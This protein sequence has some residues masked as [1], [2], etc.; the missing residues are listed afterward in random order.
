MNLMLG[1]LLEWYGHIVQHVFI[2]VAAALVIASL[3]AIGVPPPSVSAGEN[4]GPG[5]VALADRAA[6]YH[7]L[8]TYMSSRLKLAFFFYI[9]TL[10]YGMS[11]V[12][13]LVFLLFREL[14]ASYILCGISVVVTVVFEIPLFNKSKWLLERWGVSVLLVIAGLCYSFRV[15]GYTL[16]PGGW[17]VLLFEPMHGITI[18]TVTTASAEMVSSITPPEL[19]ATGQAFLGLIRGGVGSALGNSVGGAIIHLYGESACYR[20]SA[21]I[22]SLGLCVYSAIAYSSFKMRPAPAVEIV[23]CDDHVDA[24]DGRVPFPDHAEFEFPLEPDAVNKEDSSAAVIL[25]HRS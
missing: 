25:G 15:V 13:N 16:C 23:P 9:L 11:I 3:I 22:V 4:K 14:N 6:L 20:F 24:D 19:T 5:L 12:E 8:K 21:A 1:V 17:S 7:L 2:I 10:G 18:A